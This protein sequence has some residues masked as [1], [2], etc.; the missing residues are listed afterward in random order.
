MD[1]EPHRSHKD[2]DIGVFCY[3]GDDTDDIGQNLRHQDDKDGT[4]NGPYPVSGTDPR[5]PLRGTVC[6]IL[7]GF[8]SSANTE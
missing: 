7:T 2:S 5:M 1:N 3:L 4:E 8:L 6:T